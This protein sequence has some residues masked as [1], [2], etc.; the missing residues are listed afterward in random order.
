MPVFAA[1]VLVICISS[2]V[3][4]NAEDDKDLEMELA[5]CASVCKEWH[6]QQ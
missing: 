6:L 1:D 4:S 5:G 3:H 2:A